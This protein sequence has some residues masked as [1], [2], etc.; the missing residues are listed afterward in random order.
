MIMLPCRRGTRLEHN[1]DFVFEAARV[2]V[3]LDGDFWHGRSIKESLPERWKVK[4]RRNAERDVINRSALGREGWEVLS[5]WESEF[6]KQPWDFIWK[7][8]IAVFH[9]ALTRTR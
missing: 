2:A 6:M 5:C 7:V 9:R 8:R 3:F 4:L 1:A